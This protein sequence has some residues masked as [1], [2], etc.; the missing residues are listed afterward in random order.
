[1]MKKLRL[2]IIGCGNMGQIHLTGFAMLGDGVSITATCDLVEERARETARALGAQHY[3]IDYHDMVNFVDAVIVILPHQ[4][5]FEVGMF[6]IEHGKHVLMEKPLCN[7][8]EQC[9]RM[10]R[11]AEAAGITLMTA[12]PVRFWPA[13]VKLKELVN[14]ERYGDVFQMSI[15]T[16]QYTVY[17][18]ESA[19]AHTIEGLGGG[20]LFSHGCHYIDLMLWFMGKPLYGT[21]IGTRTGTPWLEGEGTSNVVIAFEDGTLGYHFGTWGARGSRNG[22]DFQIHCTRGMLEYNHQD[23][24][25]YFYS[26]METDGA[27]RK[28]KEEKKPPEVLWKSDDLSKQTQFEVR[29]FIDCIRTGKRPITDG[30][31]SLQG[32]RVIWRLYEAETRHEFADLRGL[33][34]EEPWDKAKEP[35]C[36][37]T[38]GV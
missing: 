13:I 35:V 29:H 38:G 1:M 34:L 4:L 28:M 8:E 21:H 27:E 33:G 5:H 3:F 7:T 20:Q 37:K 15:W 31:S 23:G 19:W 2:G 14:S 16:E 12:Y 18:P 26:G 36:G 11:A 24:I 22:Y 25:I 30:P 6:F 10:I 9:V 17:P 32:L